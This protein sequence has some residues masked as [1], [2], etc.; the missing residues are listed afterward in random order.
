VN[1]PLVESKVVVPP[2]PSVTALLYVYA[3]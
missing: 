1:V 3:P 2:Q